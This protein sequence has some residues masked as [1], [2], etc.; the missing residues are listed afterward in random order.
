[1]DLMDDI[2]DADD[3]QVDQE[4]S[5]ES[6]P[7]MTEWDE[8]LGGVTFEEP[9][10]EGPERPAF[11]TKLLSRFRKVETAPE[12]E[13]PDAAPD[14]EAPKQARKKPARKKA[15]GF[16]GA[17][18]VILG[19]LGVM[20]LLVYVGLIVIVVRTMRG[21]AQPASQT[22]EGGT[23]VVV[24]PSGTPV[25]WT[26]EKNQPTTV[27]AIETAVSSDTPPPVPESEGPSEGV[28]QSATPTPVPEAVPTEFDAEIS[29]DPDNADLRLQRGDEYLRL[30][31]F[32]AAARDFEHVIFLDRERAEAYV[33]LGDAYYTLHRWKEAE[34][35]Y[36]SAISFN[37]NLPGAHFGLA[38]LYYYRGN[39]TE[40]AREFD[41][42]AE[43]NPDFVEAECWLAISAARAGDKQEAIAAAGRAYSLTQELPL[44]YV[45]RSW[46][47]RV[48]DPPDLDGAQG[49]L[50]YAQ[51]VEPYDFEVLNA[52]ARFYAEY[53]PERIGEAEQLAQYAVNWA[54]TD[55]DRARGLH[56][57]G[58]VYMIQDRKE[59][60]RSVLNDAANLAMADERIAILELEEDLEKTFAP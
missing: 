28:G 29:K 59:E 36:G 21:P 33:G 39:Y 20:V 56:T 42:A 11:L 34:Q 55:W 9:L 2:L 50:L 25:D 37:E 41:W 13:S 47:L 4:Q 44:V 54:K 24:M 12:T 52:L 1:M 18:K 51:D 46:A 26:G 31:D 38:T 30:R 53:R 35:A 22:P 60:A 5:D 27:E 17:Q 48:Q 10:E 6:Q 8:L 43:I 58:R 40:A 15:G 14:A 49:D 57:L 16:T 23:L 45:A 3:E 7:G 19:V 32:E